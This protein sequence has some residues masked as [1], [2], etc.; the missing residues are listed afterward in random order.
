M[1]D[2]GGGS[3][4]GGGGQSYIFIVLAA[5]LLWEGSE[6]GFTHDIFRLLAVNLFRGGGGARSLETHFM[7]YQ[8]I[9]RGGREGGY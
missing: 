7:S 3:G 1:F 4:G 6:G 5:A 9:G 8:V 2:V